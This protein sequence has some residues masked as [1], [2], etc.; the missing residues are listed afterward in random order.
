M[1]SNPSKILL[2]VRFSMPWLDAWTWLSWVELQGRAHIY[3]TSQSTIHH[4]V[5]LT[6]ALLCHSFFL[7]WHTDSPICLCQALPT[8]FLSIYQWSSLSC[9]EWGDSAEP[10]SL[11][12]SHVGKLCCSKNVCWILSC[13]FTFLPY[14]NPGEFLKTNLTYKASINRIWML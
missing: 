7:P 10:R 3:L 9:I 12:L 14:L 8:P 2:P 13:S 1:T 5:L 6:P 11:C 4:C